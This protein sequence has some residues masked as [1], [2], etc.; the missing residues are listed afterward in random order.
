MI[1]GSVHGAQSRKKVTRL[2]Q[3][4][5][6]AAAATIQGLITGGIARLEARGLRLEADREE[7]SAVLA[8]AARG[9]VER[10]KMAGIYRAVE[11][12][13]ATI[14]SLFALQDTSGDGRLN[15]EELAAVLKAC[16]RQKKTLKKLATILVDVEQA[17]AHYDY[18]SSGYL[19]AAPARTL[20]VTLKRTPALTLAHDAARGVHQHGC[21]Q[22][23]VRFF[24]RVGGQ[25]RGSWT[26]GD[27]PGGT[28]WGWNDGGEKTTTREC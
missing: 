13:V 24:F 4:R 23:R 20:A 11:K 5:E 2:L 19:E 14:S 17:M 25:W 3:E 16:Y 28:C 26:R 1:Q 10:L 9:Y 6:D 22:R 12:E 15:H 18:D 21:L 7:Q 8:A 27:A